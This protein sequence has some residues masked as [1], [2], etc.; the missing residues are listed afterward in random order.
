[1]RTKVRIFIRYVSSTDK[2]PTGHQKMT[3]IRPLSPDQVRQHM[4]QH[5]VTL[6]RWAEEHGYPREAVYRV[7]S[8]KDKAHYGR[9]HDIACALGLKIPDPDCEPNSLV[10]DRNMQQRKVA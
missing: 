8:G 3:R 9:A 2:N 5:G 7:L 10:L 6:T 1:M 4:R